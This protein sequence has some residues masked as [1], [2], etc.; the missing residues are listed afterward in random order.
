MKRTSKKAVSILAAAMLGV[1]AAQGLAMSASA[2]TFTSFTEYAALGQPYRM[3]DYTRHEYMK[4]PTGK[5]WN[6]GNVDTVS[7]YPRDVNTQMTGG[8]VV[9]YG[10][11]NLPSNQTPSY[12]TCSAGF[13]RKLA[14]DYFNTNY[15][16]RVGA[17]KNFNLHN[18]DQVTLRT[19][20]NTLHT[21]FI[22]NTTG[23]GDI[24]YVDC[25]DDPGTCR[26]NWSNYCFIHNGAFIKHSGSNYTSFSIEY[27]DRP[28]MA[29]D[30]NGD[31]IVDGSDISAFS[32]LR[33]GQYNLS[34]KNYN[35]IR[36]AA[37]LNGD[38]NFTNADLSLFHTTNGYMTNKGFITY[39]Y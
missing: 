3:A 2:T 22:L 19:A 9:G 29:G 39:L 18:G 26:I 8:T 27:V 11:V 34:N 1:S 17:G 13:A 16:V 38:Y 28:L 36:A 20:N 4:F 12:L 32:Q 31:T 33:N 7:N 25:T 24:Q 37:D 14:Y 10:H 5:Y 35:F 23:T 15:Y 6:T 30:V 21:V